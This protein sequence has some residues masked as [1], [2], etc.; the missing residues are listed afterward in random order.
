MGNA[1]QLSGLTGDRAERT[2]PQNDH[3]DGIA[4]V[5][6]SLRQLQKGFASAAGPHPAVMAGECLGMRS[7]R[8]LKEK[9]DHVRAQ[10]RGCEIDCSGAERVSTA[11][12]QILLAFFNDMKAA[13]LPSRISNPSMELLT[14]LE[15]L[16]LKANANDWFEE[17]AK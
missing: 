4:E 10:G 7:V 3:D 2:E 11:G 12:I 15:D 17:I 5:L 14:A 9:L 8:V 16:G 1:A 13:G 6:N